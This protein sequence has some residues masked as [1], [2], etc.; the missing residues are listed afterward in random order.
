VR[1]ASKILLGLLLLSPIAAQAAPDF[2]APEPA[3][4]PP[5]QRET[6]RGA[7]DRAIDRIEWWNRSTNLR[8]E[9]VGELGR[10]N[11]N[12]YSADEAERPS[13]PP[14]FIENW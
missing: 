1:I 12:D 5:A 2:M 10:R 11:S 8:G 4:L 7:T 6:A 13:R 3:R 9:N 14:A